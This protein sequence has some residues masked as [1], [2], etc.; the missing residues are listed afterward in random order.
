MTKRALALLLTVSMLVTI[1]VGCNQK[2]PEEAPTLVTEAVTNV[3][4]DTESFRLSYSQSDSLNPYESDSLNNL[5]VEDLVFEPLFRLDESFEAEPEIASSYAY[6]DDHTLNVTIIS[7][8]TFSD[9]SA[10]NASSIVSAFENAK[11]SPYYKA[12]LEAISSASKV[13]DTEV[14]FTLSYVNNYAHQ[15]LTFPIAKANQGK[16]KYPIGSGRYKFAE[17]DGKLYLVVN[18]KYK[19]SFN[20][21]FTKIA[22]VNVPAADSVNNALNIGN[23][24]FAYR[25]S[26]ND[27]ISRLRVNKRAV[28]L[29]N[30]VYIG[31]NSNV[32]ITSNKSIR[33]AIS[34]A[35]DRSTLAKSA[36]QG[37]AR[38]ATSIFNP[39]SKLGKSTKTFSASADTAAAKQAITNSGYSDNKLSLTLLVKKSNSNA[40]ALATI[41]KQELEVV[42]FRVTLKKYSDKEYKECLKYNNYNLYIGETKLPNDMRLTSFFGAKGKTSYGINKKSET[43]KSYSA[44]LKGNTEVGSFTLNFSSEMPFVPVLYREG[45]ICYNKAMNGDMQGY[46]GNFFSNIEDWYYN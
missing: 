38:E 13:S 41:V 31:L 29:N 26:S 30:L 3:V 28:N 42:G 1:F 12:S 17:G 43:A 46:Y 35:I 11:K 24:S 37:Y 4:A 7:G 18:Q 25:D 36:Y 14:K 44:Y 32:G 27:E 39:V 34:L 2:K 22:L 23:I 6:T 8:I 5:V 33:Q 45:M 21:R 16:S 9:G 19:E 20:P 10:L 40:V 15:L